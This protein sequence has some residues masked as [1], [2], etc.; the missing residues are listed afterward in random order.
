MFGNDE[1]CVGQK[2]QMSHDLDVFVTIKFDSP[3]LEGFN[4]MI[5]N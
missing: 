5:L 4:A 3:S 2:V 1:V